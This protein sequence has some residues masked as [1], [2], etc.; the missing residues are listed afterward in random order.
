MLALSSPLPPFFSSFLR[1]DAWLPAEETG[2]LR[3]KLKELCPN[4]KRASVN[5]EIT[6]NSPVTLTYRKR[7]QESRE[8]AEKLVRL[9]L[10]GIFSK[11]GDGFGKLNQ[12][13]ANTAFSTH[14]DPKCGN[15]LTD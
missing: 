8:Q 9:K 14:L 5:L 15:H 2:F 10:F 13:N 3:K 11:H 4:S 12:A 1:F 7:N 6:I